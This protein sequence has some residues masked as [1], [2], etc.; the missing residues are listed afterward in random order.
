MAAILAAGL[1][2]A[3][4]VPVPAIAAGSGSTATAAQT[5]ALRAAGLLQPNE[6]WNCVGDGEDA[7]IRCLSRFGYSLGVGPVSWGGATF[8]PYKGNCVHY[9]AW[10]AKRAGAP[11]FFDNKTADGVSHY[12]GSDWDEAARN[13]PS[14]ARVD[15]TPE[16]GAIAQW[17]GTGYS[18]HVAYVEYVGYDSA[19]PAWIATSEAKYDE[20]KGVAKG[21]ARRA[22]YNR[23]SAAFDGADFI[24]PGGS[25]LPPGGGSDPG[26]GGGSGG[27]TGGG[28]GTPGTTPGVVVA[29]DVASTYLT[30]AYADL[31]GRAPDQS[32]RDTWGA[33]ITQTG[34]YATVAANLTG[35]DEYRNRLIA[36][37]YATYLGR[38][39]D[40]GGAATW[41]NA[42]KAGSSIEDVQVQLVLSPE[43]Y[44]NSGATTAGWVKALYD[45]ALKRGAGPSEID[46]WAGQL[47]AG[48]STEAVARA[49]ILSAEH[50][51][52][53]VDALYSSLLRRGPDAQGRASWVAQ[54]QAGVRDEQIAANLVASTEYVKR[55][56]VAYVS[57]VYGDLLGRT[58]DQQG[59]DTWVNALMTGSGFAAVA[60]SITGSDE[61]RNHVIEAA[62]ASYLG[63]A[64][65]PSGSANWLA[66]LKS[67]MTIEDV[68]ASILA[69]GEFYQA[70][71]NTDNAWLTTVYSTVLRRAG[72]PSEIAF[73]TSRLTGDGSRTG[74]AHDILFSSERLTSLVGGYYSAYLHRSGDTAGVA[75]WVSK[76]QAGWR[77]EQV[78]GGLIASEE[79]VL[80]S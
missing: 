80:S 33:T 70:A 71:G 40:P 11:S 12:N 43:F 31:L 39:A 5:A 79:Y 61:Y 69:S 52:T 55:P 15:K 44:G 22:I 78:L 60:S 65:D 2:A 41:L 6:T 48:A 67:G 57:K 74:V 16:R 56:L 75:S 37:S 45:K 26:T 28:T 68:Q 53:V 18:N 24:H 72:S 58:P 73:W 21:G 29:S 32:G 23:G 1:A 47:A 77:D 7:V 35:S 14:K 19:G 27:G 54:M 25:P 50:Y 17:D 76:L 64:P 34:S 63:R 3:T 62:Y 66:A 10:S 49:I 51:G 4:L 46:F 20:V 30:R 42:M 13:G 9:A 38:G 8:L 36:D 59:L